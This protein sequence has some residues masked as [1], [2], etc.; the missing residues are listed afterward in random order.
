MTGVERLAERL[1]KLDAISL[2][3]LSEGADKVTQVLGAK[4]WVINQSTTDRQDVQRHDFVVSNRE[5]QLTFRYFK[6]PAIDRTL[7]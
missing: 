2:S 4:V 1:E 7:Q 6:S 5:L 3:G